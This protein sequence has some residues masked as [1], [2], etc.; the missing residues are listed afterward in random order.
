MTENK[1][2]D[3]LAIDA[4]RV[5]TAESVQKAK[6]GHPGMALGSAALAYEIWANQMK[7]NPRDPRW[8]N[9]DRFVLSAGHA[10]ML[11][12]ALLYLFDYGLT[13]DDL[14]SFRQWESKTPGHPEFGHTAGVEATTGPLGQ[15]LSMAVGMALA[16]AHMAARFNKPG[17][18]LFDHYVYV[19]SGDGCMMEG[20][21]GEAASLA[22]TM[23]LGRLIVFYDDN[24]ISIEGDTDVSFTEDVGKRHEAYGWQVIHVADGND[25]TAIAQAIAEAKSDLSRPT[26]I[27]VKTAIGYGSPLAGDAKTHGEP[28]GEDNV[29]KTKEM[30]G[31]PGKSPFDVPA[32]LLEYL[33]A[34]TAGIARSQEDWQQLRQAYAKAYPEDAARLDD[35]LDGTLLDLMNDE[36]FWSFSGAQATRA[37]SG[38]CLNRLAE[39]LPNLI[40][41]SADLAPSTKTVIKDG[42]WLSAD[43]YEGINIHFGVREH[44]MAAVSNGI[45]LY[46]GLRPF[47][48]TFFVFSDYMKGAMRL[49]AL[50]KLPVIYVLTHDSI[51]VGEDGPT[52]EPIEHLAA[53]RATPDMTVFRPADGKETAA[54]YV[55]ALQNQGPTCLVLTRQNLPTL[56]GTGPEALKGGYVLQ[57][58][59]DPD[60]ILMASGSEVELT[61]QA[62]AVLSNDGIKSRVVSMPSMEVFEKQPQAY[63]E[64]V[65]PDR[66]RKRLAVEAG[67]TMPWYRYIGLDGKVI[68]IDHFGA[69]APAA[70]LFEQFGF[71]V[72][73]LVA[74]AKVLL[75]ED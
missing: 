15:G 9:R 72:E 55:L 53:L 62:A 59:A 44:A 63:K 30:A 8:M 28:L 27:I 49:S 14:K 32:E 57:D 1:K 23:K 25:R 58:A 67:T 26:M 3:Q 51:G 71:T 24:N 66:L 37:T 33:K 5:L 31:W 19:L 54:G 68:G 47:C 40:G 18:D 61:L 70:T 75:A 7:F 2:L 74:E 69:S 64:S 12:Y 16:Q 60:L 46:G 56:D 10:S 39:R 38:T 42:G 20:L 50:M 45:A 34:K 17:F 41:G 21:T 43:H 48:A 36:A 29:A 11:L 65:L 4:I 22:G 73:N 6:S 52:H 13:L 35:C